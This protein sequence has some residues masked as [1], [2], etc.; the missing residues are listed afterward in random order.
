MPFRRVSRTPLKPDTDASPAG[1]Q[2]TSA[3]AEQPTMGSLPIWTPD[4]SNRRDS[5]EYQ[6]ALCL[7]SSGAPIVEL[8]VLEGSALQDPCIVW[9]TWKFGSPE[10]HMA[11]DYDLLRGSTNYDKYS[12]KL[13]LR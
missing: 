13:I 6:H 4:A 1:P 7:T 10:K 11:F 5:D 2:S 3:A 12:E 9:A 8:V